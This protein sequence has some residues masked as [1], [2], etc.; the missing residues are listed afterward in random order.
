MD[1]TKIVQEYL[2]NCPQEKADKARILDYIV[3]FS[4]VLTR[5]NPLCHFTASA[6][7]TN[8]E[9]TKVVMVWHNIYRSWSWVGGHA[10]GEA[11]LLGV[12]LRE[13]AEETG[14]VCQ[15]VSREPIS[16]EILPVPGHI[17]GG[18]YVPAHLHM[19]L[20]FLLCAQESQ[21]LRVKPD[22]NSGVS[23]FSPEE[24]LL[25]T[26]EEDMRPIYAKLNARL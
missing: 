23:W 16:L 14:L 15:P 10:D 8:A 1:L 21:P 17:K 6:W 18:Q 19:N 7:I 12:A 11:D 5:Q 13:A 24:A 9:H 22:E 2:P 26:R 3:R 20:T 4:D 25:R